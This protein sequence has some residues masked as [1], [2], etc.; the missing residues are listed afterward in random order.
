MFSEVNH[1]HL[2]DGL[3]L[4]TISI[5]WMA[6]H[7]LDGKTEMAHP[8]GA[9]TYSTDFTE[10]SPISFK[11]EMKEYLLPLKQLISLINDLSIEY[12]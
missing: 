3:A 4:S 9:S 5:R 10:Y 1:S 11:D 7:D 8:F 6:S 2:A 12:Q